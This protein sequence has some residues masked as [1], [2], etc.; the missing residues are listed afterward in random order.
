MRKLQY[1]M[2]LS[3][4]LLTLPSFMALV[5]APL[6]PVEVEK[7]QGIYYFKIHGVP[8]TAFHELEGVQY[9]FAYVTYKNLGSN[10]PTVTITLTYHYIYNPKTPEGDH[11]KTES[12]YNDVAAG[13]TWQFDIN[14]DCGT[15]VSFDLTVGSDLVIDNGEI[16]IPPPPN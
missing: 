2:I 5:T 11:W 12:F 10:T 14:A 9:G 16:I 13:G 7:E 6:I 15:I 4:I 3:T 8:G 1:I